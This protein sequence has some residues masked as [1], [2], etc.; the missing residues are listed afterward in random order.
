MQCRLCL[1]NRKLCNSHIVPE[2][3]YG[4]LYNDDHKMMGINGRGNRGW[5]PLQIGSREHL[6][7]SDCERHL[8]DKYEKLFHKQWLVDLPLPDRIPENAP[9]TVV[10]DYLTFKLF[11]LSILFRASVSS[12]PTFR[13]VNLGVVHEERIRKMLISESPGQD[14]EYPIH[15]FAVLNGHGKVEKRLISCPIS[16]R[17]EGHITYGQIYGGAMWWI[18]ASSHRNDP[19]CRAGLQPS[20]EMTMIAVPWNEIGVMQDASTALKRKHL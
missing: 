6:L 15:A 14:W 2:F 13:E 18:L 16:A 3:L 5:K 4:D 12:L 1:K 10:Y 7:C 20:G 8:N 19:F 11:H 9:H 17:Y